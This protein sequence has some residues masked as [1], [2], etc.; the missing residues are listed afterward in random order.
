MENPNSAA[1]KKNQPWWLLFIEGIFAIILGGILLWAPSKTQQNTWII[2]VVVL[3]FYWLVTGIL[4]LVRLSQYHKRWGWKLFTGILSILAGVYILLYPAASAAALPSIIILVL[5]ILGCMHG[6]MR[7]ISAFDGGGWGSAVIGALLIILGIILIVNFAN[8]AFGLT[9]I[10]IASAI[11]FI[12]GF[13]LI[14]K[15]FRHQPTEMLY[16]Y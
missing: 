4:S 13:V 9:L 11:I 15:S 10:F 5:G 8:P 1:V 12:M 14:F 2:L 6:L 16:Y 3:G 7:V